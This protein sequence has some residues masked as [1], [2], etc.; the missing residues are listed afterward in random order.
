MNKY[1]PIDPDWHFS[2][3]FKSMTKAQSFLAQG[4]ERL[5][6]SPYPPDVEEERGLDAELK[7][8]ILLAVNQ[9]HQA[10]ELFSHEIE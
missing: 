10:L 1:P 9:C 6:D 2:S 7:Q 8:L 4:V 5:L 3:A